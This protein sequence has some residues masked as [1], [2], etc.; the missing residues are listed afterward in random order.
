MLSFL[1]FLYSITKMI[2]SQDLHVHLGMMS[3]IKAGHSEYGQNYQD[4]SQEQIEFSYLL[5]FLGNEH[6]LCFST[7][8]THRF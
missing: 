4:N 6:S 3:D 5:G 1:I 8:G 7:E 2:N